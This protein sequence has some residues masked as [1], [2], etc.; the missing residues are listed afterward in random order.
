M[1]NA[2][3]DMTVNYSSTNVL[4]MSATIKTNTDRT[5]TYTYNSS[6]A[7]VSLSD[8]IKIAVSVSRSWLELIESWPPAVPA[9]IGT[10]GWA[11]FSSA[12]ALDFSKATEGLEA[13]MITGHEGNVVTKSQV[14]G[15]VPA[16][17]GL[18]LKG[19]AGNYTIPV[20]G[21]SDTDVSANKLVAGT[22]EAVDA[23][24]G[25]TRYVL[26]VNN[27]S[28]PDDDS[29]DFAEFQKIVGTPATVATGKAYLQFN[30]NSEARALRMSFGDETAVESVKAAAE[31]AKKNGAYLENGK[32]A[33]YK[34]GVK[35]NVAGQQ[36]K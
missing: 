1:D 13:Y 23:G 8:D 36:M 16:G 25:V 26:G 6:T 3:V 11:T 27:N 12:Y 10:Y 4:T 20:V 18:L 7:G 15:T 29:D 34:N 35:F 30:G 17:T 33:I 32:I 24:S 19:A 2:T 9:T 22:G 21:S 31:T 5:L 28:T 14:T